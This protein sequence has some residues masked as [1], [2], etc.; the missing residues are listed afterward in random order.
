MDY[1]NIAEL[2]RNGAYENTKEVIKF[3]NRINF[4]ELAL[5]S[6][7]ELDD[8]LDRFKIGNDESEPENIVEMSQEENEVVNENVVDLENLEDFQDYKN[9]TSGINEKIGYGESKNKRSKDK[10]EGESVVEFQEDIQEKA[11]SES[12]EDLNI[13]TNAEK[14]ALIKEIEFSAKGQEMQELEDQL[15]IVDYVPEDK[16]EKREKFTKYREQYNNINELVKKYDKY[17]Q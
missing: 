14:S 11:D 17:I 3:E 8:F 16:E 10:I 12:G 7:A 2:L 5:D 4:D 6:E 13:D 15:N 9:F 1:M